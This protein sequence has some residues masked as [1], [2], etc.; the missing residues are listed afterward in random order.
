MFQGRPLK[1]HRCSGHTKFTSSGR[2]ANRSRI[3]SHEKR[4]C[5]PEIRVQRGIAHIQSGVFSGYSM[6]SFTAFTYHF[7]NFN[8]VKLSQAQ[9]SQHLILDR[10]FRFKPLKIPVTYART[11]DQSLK[12]KGW[13]YFGRKKTLQSCLQLP[14]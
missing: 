5:E 8:L 11:P 10:P 7:H 14:D 12:G 3:L 4:Y 13:G 1:L 6:K 2:D 9:P